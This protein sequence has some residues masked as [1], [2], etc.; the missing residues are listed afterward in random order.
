MCCVVAGESAATCSYEQI[1]AVWKSIRQSD[2]GATGL[3]SGLFHESATTSKKVLG[4]V[5]VAVRTASKKIQGVSGV[6]F[7]RQKQTAIT[8]QHAILPSSCR[9]YLISLFRPSVFCRVRAFAWFRRTHF[10][11]SCVRNMITRNIEQLPPAHHQRHRVYSIHHLLVALDKLF[12]TH[13][14]VSLP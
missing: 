5:F 8:S 4:L 7:L 12:L 6:V 13:C 3:K 10:T 14:E 11:W 1:V 9:S 2:A